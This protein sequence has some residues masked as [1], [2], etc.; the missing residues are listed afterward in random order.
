MKR[1]LLMLII[2]FT[3]YEILWIGIKIQLEALSFNIEEMVWDFAQCTL[4]TS[5]LFIVNWMFQKL[6]GGRYAK[7]VAEMLTML[8]VSSLLIYLVDYFI[9]MQDTPDDRIWNIIDIYIIC[10][11][12][13]L[14]SIISMQYTYHKRFVKLKQEQIGLRLS[15]LQQQLSPHFMFNSLSTLQGMIAS[16]PHKA[17]EYVLTLS[18]ILRYVTDNISCDQVALSEAVSFIKNYSQLLEMRFPQHFLFKI[19]LSDIPS[20]AFIIPVSLQIAVENAIKHNGH[21]TR[22]PLEISI[23]MDSNYIVV[24]NQ[25]QA[26]SFSNNTETGIGLT[27]LNERYRLLTGKGLEINDDKDIFSVKIPLLYESF[28]CRR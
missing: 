2:S 21:S 23:I 8:S 15:L 9:Y 11:I 24:S 4:F 20:N 16:E 12:C 5:A 3:M 13:T 7:G 25:K 28:D 14:L 1:W 18:V 6:Q 19:A 26:V 17:E 27:N 22:K 10:I